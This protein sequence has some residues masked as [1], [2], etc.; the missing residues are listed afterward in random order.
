M[1]WGRK[2]GECPRV[3][4]S[5]WVFVFF[6][7]S[8]IH[9][10]FCTNFWQSVLWNL[11]ERDGDKQEL[12]GKNRKHKARGRSAD[13]RRRDITMQ[14][15]AEELCWS[16]DFVKEK[17]M[18]IS[19]LSYPY[20]PCLTMQYNHTS[21]SQFYFSSISVRHPIL[22]NDSTI[23]VPL[24]HPSCLSCN[25]KLHSL[26]PFCF[27]PYNAKNGLHKYKSEFSWVSPVPKEISASP[28]NY[29]LK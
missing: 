25:E 9:E 1:R 26:T 19:S 18:S 5:K 13:W 16:N 17:K 2:H 12:Q 22:A 21:F 7:N 20:L 28:W 14:W 15:W 8:K 11:R 23:M 4:P 27:S 24:I 10:V 3:C 6:I 29:F